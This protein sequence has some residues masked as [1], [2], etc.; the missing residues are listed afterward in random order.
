MITTNLYD[1]NEYT[2]F[3]LN[4][5]RVSTDDRELDELYDEFSPINLLEDENTIHPDL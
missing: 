2:A 4:E 3:I 1:D 5:S